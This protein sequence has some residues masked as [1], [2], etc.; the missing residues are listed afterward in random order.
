MPGPLENLERSM[1]MRSNIASPST[2]NNSAIARLN[3][4]DELI[5]PKVPAVRITTSP[6][7]P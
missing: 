6:S 7:T 5:V 2:M 3:H 4:G 1:V